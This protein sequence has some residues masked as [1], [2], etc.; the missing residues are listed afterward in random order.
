MW[1]RVAAHSSL[2]PQVE[3]TVPSCPGVK[4]G[5]IP[6]LKAAS[7]CTGSTPLKMCVGDCWLG[8]ATGKMGERRTG[9]AGRCIGC[10]FSY[11]YSSFFWC[12]AV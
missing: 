12:R 10:S 4:L 11:M 6:Q 7:I 9:P 8:L 2:C 5:I 1:C 3:S